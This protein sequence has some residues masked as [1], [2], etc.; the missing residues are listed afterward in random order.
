MCNSVLHPRAEIRRSSS[1][2]QDTFF[3]HSAIY[4]DSNDIFIVKITPPLSLSL[5][6]LVLPSPSPSTYVKLCTKNFNKSLNIFWKQSVKQIVL[7]IKHSTKVYIK[8]SI[9]FLCIIYNSTLCNN[10]RKWAISSED[11][12]FSTSRSRGCRKC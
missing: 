10:G 8:A 1:S 9:S 5:F 3:F 12:V 2:R 7:L 4:I 6:L 11:E